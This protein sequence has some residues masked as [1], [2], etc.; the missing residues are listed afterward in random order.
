MKIAIITGGSRGL[1]KSA[2]LHTAA[3]GNDVILTY[4]SSEAEAKEVVRE[5]ENLGRKA[6]ALQLD[7]AKVSTFADFA[8]RVRQA[9]QEK[10]NVERFDL[11]VNNAGIG[12]YTP[13]MEY[14]EE[15]F[16]RVVNTHFKG[17][18]F[19]TQKLLPLMN[20][21][22]RIVNV[23][24]GLA[25]FSFPGSSVYGAAKAAVEALTR[26]LAKELGER[27]ITANVV[28]PG[29]IATDFGEGRVRN[30]PEMQKQLSAMTP[31]G[32]VGNADDI[33]GLV[34]SLLE[35]GARWVNGQRIE[36]SGGM[37]T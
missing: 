34:A 37:L 11:L 17:V 24:S 5:I 13:I 20:D 10:W 19:L 30:S 8:T 12:Q 7:V 2:A 26:Y 29:P 6:V 3:R 18:F 36:A 31:L 21:G 25:R 32:R 33:G 27:R 4:L 1:G 22:G 23:S 16:D 15:D 28:A 14:T 35:D 9:L